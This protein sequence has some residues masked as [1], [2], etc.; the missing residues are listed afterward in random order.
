[1]TQTT[2]T[3]LAGGTIVDG[4]GAP[5]IT[6]DVV[7]R[8]GRIVSVLRNGGSRSSPLPD[9]ACAV[10]D[11]REYIVAPGFI[12]AHSH[13]DLQVIDNHTEKLL[14]GVTAE[15]VGNCGFS[16]YPS[17]ENPQ[18]LRDF[19]NGI[20]CG[21]DG[22]SWNSAAAY[23][24]SARESKVATVVSLVGHGS[25]RI[26]VA[27][28]TTRALT[29]QE[30]D[31]M[32]GLLDDA[33]QEGASGFSSGLMYAPGSGATP[34]ELT[35]LCRVA[36]RRNRVY[37]THMRNYSAGVVKSVEEQLWIAA[38]SGCRLQISHLQA[39]GQDNWPL[40]QQ[41][42][43]AIEE[44]SEK[45]VDVGFDAYPWLAGSTVLTQVLPQTA[46][47][48]GMAP[49]L[50][51]LRDPAQREAISGQIK[52]EAYWNGVIITSVADNSRSLVG[53]S[54]QEIA[55]ERGTNPEN[56]VMD[57]LLEQQG[58]VNIVEHCQSLENLYVLLTH[59]LAI[60][61]TDGVYTRGRSHPRL[62]A[63]YPLLFAEMVRERKW[64][65]MED[66]VHK[67]T[68]R[69][70][71][72]FHL[73]DRGRIAEGCV[74]DITVFNPDTIHTKATYEMPDVPPAGIK[75]VMRSGAAAVKEG[76]VV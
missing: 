22:W 50:E 32:C 71:S 9:A 12:D 54:V 1:M 3:I 20:L 65:S 16:A 36:A 45:G 37:A 52:S 29:S 58:N 74:A 30:L 75:L 60:V 26:K 44:A 14:Q 56:T 43:A 17:P 53:R 70:A 35:A 38:D 21:N 39:A 2:G 51:R 66:A 41:A 10:I 57:I 13:S 67:V 8:D 15:V 6:G 47:D 42:I 68:G 34:R 55:D 40:Q 4:T 48:G 64:L 7:I 31:T 23:L 18:V 69:P 5:A 76:I 72:V 24:A 46:L 73:D 28:N 11:C 33:L 25:L 49:L 27:G 63:T 59:P 62:Y 61:I 19:A